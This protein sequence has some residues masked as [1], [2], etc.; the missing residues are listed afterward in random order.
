MRRVVTERRR[1]I[2]L[3]ATV[4]GTL[5]VVS[6]D[7]PRKYMPRDAAQE[8]GATGGKG[9]S[10]ASTSASGGAFAGSGG[11]S[12]SGGVV[13]VG[14]E[15]GPTTG[16]GGTSGRPGAG[17]TNAT[18]GSGGAGMG[19]A[20]PTTCPSGKHDCAGTCSE[21]TSPATCGQS[22]TPCTVPAG[23][24]A[25]CDGTT[26]GFTCGGSTPKKCAAAGICVAMSAC[27]TNSDCPTNAGG[28]TGTCD[29][30]TH[31]CNYSCAGST[32][33]CTIAGATMCIPSTGCC[34][35]LDCP[36]SCA[37]C[38]TTSHACVAVK[39]MDDPTGRCAGT[40]DASGACK[41]KQGQPCTAAAQCV[42]GNC[43][44]GVCCNT[45]CTGSCE[46]CNG[47]T[48]GTCGF[49]SGAPK[50]GHTA[51]GGTGACAGS[52][53]GTKATCK[54]PGTETMCRTSS[55][56]NGTQTNAAV[57]NGAG[58]CP[59]STTTSCGDYLCNGTTSCYTSCTAVSQCTA[60]TRC[61]APS[62]LKCQTGEN[63]CSNA[64]YKTDTDP[65]HCGTTCKVCS[66]PTPSCSAGTCKCRQPSPG[67]ILKNPGL[68]GSIANWT[69]IATYNRQNDAEGCPDSGSISIVDFTDHFRQCFDAGF[70]PG[71]TY[72]FAL[73][74]KAATPDVQYSYCGIGAFTG[75]GCDP[76]QRLGTSDLIAVESNGT[77]WVPG[78]VSWLVPSNTT[79][80][81]VQ[82]SAS[83]GHGYFD[84]LVLRQGTQATY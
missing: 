26:C 33:S 68:D 7:P 35:N 49:V 83:Q 84:H 21:N 74:Y 38:N 15:A 12:G 39:G 65:N 78:S 54:M 34:T 1:G 70:E 27:C 81:L 29:T 48:P 52:C 42:T 63:V 82:C 50:A 10:G 5:L 6:C 55:C 3:W 13:G 23:A 24:T 8:G 30:A 57:C 28:L 45:A 17:G 4:I 60:N 16:S 61:N 75:T 11:A 9:G 69:G 46:F 51:C 40:C 19:G 77:S 62:C 56:S 20:G 67:N 72:T 44:D 18:G 25:T 47:I 79:S 73:L 53:D 71:T 41:T 14:G 59:A 80:L 76:E 31:M 32:T 37:T 58:T 36:G 43:A 22:C 66:L 2:G 64:C